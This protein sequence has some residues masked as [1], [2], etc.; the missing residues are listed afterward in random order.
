MLHRIKVKRGIY[1]KA[2]RTP[3]NLLKCNTLGLKERFDLSFSH[4]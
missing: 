1:P 2:F 4:F 3:G